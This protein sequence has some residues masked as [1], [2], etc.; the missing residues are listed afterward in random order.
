LLLFKGVHKGFPLESAKFNA[1]QKVR[2]M[3]TNQQVVD[4]LVWLTSKYLYEKE[5]FIPEFE[6]R[7]IEDQD[8]FHLAC[9]T[10][11]RLMRLLN[12]MC[13]S[14][15]H[16]LYN[17]S[18]LMLDVVTEE[19]IL[20]YPVTHLREV[21]VETWRD[22]FNDFFNETND[23]TDFEGIIPEIAPWDKALNL[24]KFILKHDFKDVVGYEYGG[25]F[26]HV[27]DYYNTVQENI[28]GYVKSRRNKIIKVL[29]ELNERKIKEEIAKE[30][31]VQE[32]QVKPL[33]KPQLTYQ[34]IPYTKNREYIDFFKT[35]PY[36]SDEV[37]THLLKYGTL[38]YLGVPKELEDFCRV[39]Y[40]FYTRNGKKFAM[41]PKDFQP[42]FVPDLTTHNKEINELAKY[43]SYN[44]N[45]FDEWADEGGNTIE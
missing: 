38:R 41:L 2:I 33:P 26:F 12:A 9:L 10:D 31:L 5:F 22:V 11:A 6:K 13:N 29:D 25:S 24:M 21:W 15:P 39:K 36:D 23:I 7:A 17:L 16:K 30:L 20:A 37:T 4:K 19:N 45:A 27:Q 42:K 28:N 8:K 43:T 40:G 32:R 34:S 1:K 18:G 44:R 14:Y 35:L 3:F